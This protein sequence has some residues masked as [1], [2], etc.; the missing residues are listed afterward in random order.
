MTRI[1]QHS[2]QI[3][4][5]YAGGERPEDI[6][7]DLGCSMGAIYYQLKRAGVIIDRSAARKKAL[8]DRNRLPPS[9]SDQQ[10][11]DYRVL[12]KHGYRHLDAVA[13][14]ERPKERPS[15]GAVVE[16]PARDPLES[17]NRPPGST[18]GCAS[19]AIGADATL[20]SVPPARPV[21]SSPRSAASNSARAAR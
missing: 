11:D 2:A 20:G 8:A 10:I 21:V 3:A 19:N 16:R 6:A 14:V 7:R 1:A 12:R 4:R 17:A 13:T 5:R 15:T 18:P 9:W